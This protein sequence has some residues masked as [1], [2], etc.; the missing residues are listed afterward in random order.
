MRPE[1]RLGTPHPPSL[2]PTPALAAPFFV[3]AVTRGI[4][5]WNTCY[6]MTCI[7][8]NDPNRRPYR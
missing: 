2:P 5:P 8:T 6:S 4:W 1:A 3:F 7:T